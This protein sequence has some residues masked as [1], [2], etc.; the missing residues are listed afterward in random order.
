MANFDNAE[1]VRSMCWRDYLFVLFT[2]MCGGLGFSGAVRPRLEWDC[3]GNPLKLGERRSEMAVSQ[4]K[5]VREFI[6]LSS[7]LLRRL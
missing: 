5:D 3:Y 6:G 7:D 2:P 4:V 1:Y